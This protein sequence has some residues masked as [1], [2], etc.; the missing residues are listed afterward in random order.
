MTLSASFLILALL[1]IA[2]LIQTLATVSIL[3]VATSIRR[4]LGAQNTDVGALALFG[5]VALLLH[6]G[7]FLAPHWWASGR[8][9]LGAATMLPVALLVLAALVVVVTQT[10]VVRGL[11]RSTRG[12]RV[13]AIAAGGALVLAYVGPIVLMLAASG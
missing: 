3:V 4:N 10:G 12:R 1:W 7:Y 5:I 6:T 9:L 8:H 13:A 11:S 2:P